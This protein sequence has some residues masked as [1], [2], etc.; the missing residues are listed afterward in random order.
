MLFLSIVHHYLLWHY[1][2]AFLEIFH[3]WLNLMWFIV[4]F[5]S[6]PELMMSW[7]SPWKRITEPRRNKWSL[8]D[9]AGS[10]II[11]LLSRIIGFTL[12]T[13]VIC[14]G[15]VCLFTLIIV[16]LLTYIFWIIAP[17]M[18]IIL[19]GFGIALIVA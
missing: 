3:V 15:L 5:F 11:G 10:I 2:R 9:L 6:I 19:I 14:I 16:G 1:S 4:H 17:M 18:I 7:F 13:L 8:E 12:R